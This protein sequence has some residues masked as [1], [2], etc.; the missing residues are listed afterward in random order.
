LNTQYRSPEAH[1]DDSLPSLRR[2]EQ[3]C[4]Q[5]GRKWK[6]VR[7]TLLGYCELHQ[8]IGAIGLRENE[9]RTHPWLVLVCF[10]LLSCA[11]VAQVAPSGG[12]SRAG[13]APLAAPIDPELNGMLRQIEQLASSINLELGKLRVEKWKTDSAS[14]RQ[15]EG[16]IDS[17]QRNLTAALPE[18]ITAVRN[19]PKNLAPGFRLYRNL[20]AL[21]DVLKSLAESAG[22]FVPKDQYELLAADINGLE[23]V[24]TA[25]GKRVE[26]LAEAQALEIATLR[27]QLIQARAQKNVVDDNAAAAKPKSTPRKKPKPAP[28]AQSQPQQ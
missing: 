12:A 7:A 2:S 13:S 5:R 27:Q 28:P 3:D 24:R 11:L 15:A 22:A 9:L 23:A 6:L 1:L 21:S 10:C 8:S 14:K 17:M 18:F 26:S 16:T 19:S 20:N 25:F 4:I